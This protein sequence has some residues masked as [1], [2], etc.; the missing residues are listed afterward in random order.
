MGLDFRWTEGGCPVDRSGTQRVL[1]I[2]DCFSQARPVLKLSEISRYAG[3]SLTTTHRQVG[4]LTR[5]GALERDDDGGYRIGLRLW[6][7]G[8]L[9]PRSI[10]LREAALPFLEDLYEATHENVQLAVLDG[11]EAV[12]VERIS[13]RHAVH[14]VTRPGSR[15]PVHAT[16]VGLVLLAHAGPERVEEVL[17]GPLTRY[18]PHTVTDPGALRRILADVR[19]CGY[20]ISDRQIEVVSTSVAAPVRGPG[21][22]VVAALSVVVGS[23]AAQARRYVPAVRTAARGISRHLMRATFIS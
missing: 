6:E 5:W 4:E 13:G 11:T 15:L 21:E 14:V 9:A 18:T 22:E 7:V 10:G 1:A 16:A 17:A 3:L 20:V 2:L 23:S 12:Y 19:R 8:S